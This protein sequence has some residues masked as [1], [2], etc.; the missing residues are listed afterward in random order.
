MQWNQYV[1]GPADNPRQQQRRRA[2]GQL[3]EQNNAPR[4]WPYQRAPQTPPSC[5]L[6]SFLDRY[7]ER[8]QWLQHPERRFALWTAEEKMEL[9]EGLQSFSASRQ[10]CQ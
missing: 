8:V 7:P 5:T 1:A 6:Q 2:G 9:I 10:N 3:A 4:H